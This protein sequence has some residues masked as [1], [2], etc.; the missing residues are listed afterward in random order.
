MWAL[1]L[2]TTT[3]I[4][5]SLPVLPALWEWKLKRDVQPLGINQGHTG[6]I[7]H[8]ADTFRKFV[9]KNHSKGI[10]S[11]EPG[12]PDSPFATA[13]AN[14]LSAEDGQA[15]QSG[16]LGRVLVAEST[17]V[18][19]D[20][21]EFDQEI[22]ARTSLGTGV[23]SH[24]RG[25]LSR[26]H[27]LIRRNG[28]VLRWAH[29]KSVVIENDCLILGRLS[30]D[31]KI[32]IQAG[33]RFTRLNAP[34]V[35]FGDVDIL[36]GVTD[37]LNDMLFGHGSSSGE[38]QLTNGDLQLPEN[39][40]TQADV[41]VRGNLLI[42]RHASVMGSVKSHGNMTLERG[43]TVS[44]ALVCGGLLTIGESC[45]LGGPVVAERGI[46]VDSQVVIG[47]PNHRA[48]VTSPEIHIVEGVVVHGT[49]WARVHGKVLSVDTAKNR[50][51]AE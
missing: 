5:F 46:H 40:A 21:A 33:T 25:V 12:A 1:L 2:F 37:W 24:F 43:V 8:F 39:S 19:P 41:I 13:R 27:L 9:R 32:V 44:G 30:A 28:V 51:A 10:R 34:R 45:R 36:S 22:F 42:Q 38:R 23:N 49:V 11:D 17:C 47:S 18:L 26:S 16:R 6:N 48:T 15:A 7:R 35:V 14:R 29:G 20:Y 50:G 3:L 4:L 31:E